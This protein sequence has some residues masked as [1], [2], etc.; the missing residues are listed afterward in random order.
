MLT[1]TRLATTHSDAPD[2]AARVELDQSGTNFVYTLFN[3]EP[4]ASSWHVSNWHLEVGA[5]FQVLATPPGWSF[6]TDYATYVDW[7]STDTEE[8][9]PHDVAP[10]D[11]LAGFALGAVVDTPEPLSYVALSWEHG[12][13]APGPSVMASVNSPSVISFAAIILNVLASADRFEFSVQGI[14][15]LQYA[16]EVS[17]DLT[18]WAQV[19]TGTSPFTFQE[20]PLVSPGARFFRV[21]YV[22]SF[23]EVSDQLE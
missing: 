19:M 3:E 14:P 6:A 1:L 12:S 18:Q 23:G 17:T 7:F 11:S 13:T 4:V 15:S 20:S 10:G 5:P 9:Y 8:P 21:R 16:V 2:L 22:D